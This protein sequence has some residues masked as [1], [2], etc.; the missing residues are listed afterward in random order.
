MTSLAPPLLPQRVK[1]S[2]ERMVQLSKAGH[3][4]PSIARRLGVSERTVFRWLN[5]LAGDG[6][7][8]MRPVVSEAQSARAL[9]LLA[10]GVPAMWVAEEV[11]IDPRTV[12]DLRDRA[13]LPR[14]EE[15][16]RIRLQI[17]HDPV[18]FALHKE[19]DPR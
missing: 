2:P 10:E 6:W 16:K 19:F 1:A 9:T 3:A 14:D 15:W 18:L 4:P 17:Q 12:R 7:K 5:R 13:G 8:T 11:G